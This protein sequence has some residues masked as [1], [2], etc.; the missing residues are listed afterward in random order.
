MFIVTEYA[1][2]NGSRYWLYL[3]L[4]PTDGVKVYFHDFEHVT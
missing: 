2:L 1:A 4:I 3:S